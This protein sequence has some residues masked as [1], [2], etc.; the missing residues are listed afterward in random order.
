[1]KANP[2]VY[3][4]KIEATNNRFSLKQTITMK[5][6]LKLEAIKVDSFI[7]DKGLSAI[8]GAGTHR[9]VCPPVDGTLVA[10]PA[11]SCPIRTRDMPCHQVIE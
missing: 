7:T 2:K 8:K 10:T 3:A 6:K 11:N 4:T 5:A 9:I 1:M